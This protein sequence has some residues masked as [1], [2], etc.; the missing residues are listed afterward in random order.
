MKKTYSITDAT[1]PAQIRHGAIGILPTDTIYG[2]VA[3]A[4]NMR[5][6]ERVYQAKGRSPKKPCIILVDSPE[7]ITGFG[8]PPEQIAKV[9]QYWPGAVSVIFWDIAEELA[10]LHRG[11]HSLSFRVPA[12]ET[13]RGFLANTGPIIAPSANKEGQLSAKNIQ[14]AMAA[15]G[16]LADFYVDGGQLVGEP[17][18]LIRIEPN[19]S[20]TILRQGSQKIQ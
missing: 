6:V 10:Y 15:F 12:D 16:D 9:S 1:L 4:F 3:D 19:D 8:V 18:T 11:T 7:A 5:A 14:E 2:I 20:L 17:S 13:L